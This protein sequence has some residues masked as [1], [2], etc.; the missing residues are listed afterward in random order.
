MAA[1]DWL[2][3]IPFLTTAGG[4]RFNKQRVVEL[5]VIVATVYGTMQV[6]FAQIDTLIE[7]SKVQKSANAA[8]KAEVTDIRL[9]RASRKT[10]IDA[11]IEQVK[12]HEARL[13]K[14]GK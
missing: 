11:V 10:Q 13:R 9:E 1:P 8:L 6:K 7:D 4:S 5:I 14:A 12:D 3:I 2:S